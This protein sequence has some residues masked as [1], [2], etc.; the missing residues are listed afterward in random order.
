M[1]Y[2]IDRYS[3]NLFDPGT[4]FPLNISDNTINS[5]STSIRL[6]GRGV[7][8]YGEIV[9]ETMVHMMENFAGLN[10]PTAPITGQLWWQQDPTNSNN[11]QKLYV[12]N[13][14]SWKSVMGATPSNTG[15]TGPAIGDLWYDL[16]S[17]TLNVWDG[18][19]WQQIFAE[20]P[21]SLPTNP[22]VT[23][24]A[25]P[26]EG[27][28]WYN[29]TNDFLHTYNG[30]IWEALMKTDNDTDP[31]DDT[32]ISYDVING[33]DVIIVKVNGII[34]AIWSST[35]IANAVLWDGTTPAGKP[36]IK[37][38]YPDGLFAGTNYSN[39][40]N[41]GIS[42]TNAK[43][44]GDWT[45]AAGASFEATYADIAERYESDE[46][47]VPGTL[48]GLGGTK[49][50]T[51]TKGFGDTSVFGVV[52]SAPAFVLNHKEDTT[53]FPAIALAGRVPVL[54]DGPVGKGDRL[55]ASEKPGVAKAF[56]KE[57]FVDPFDAVMAVFGRALESKSTWEVA[58]VEVAVGAK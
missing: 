42:G 54:V 53:N 1:P 56:R 30:S 50:V 58:L 52:S 48:V 31:T 5:T 21:G 46:Q 36:N 49:E 15:P 40:A 33:V 25:D 26:T 41:N 23:A 44:F 28:L 10:A 27:M 14:T 39:I 4:S 16:V 3:S 22:G 6:M 12:W 43:I 11:A 19:S 18:T 17:N 38:M 24:P 2:S 35:T 9:A 47:L 55:V 13:G 7:S 34:V 29:T 20:I 45:L 32:F 57:D 37:A 51:K 8:N